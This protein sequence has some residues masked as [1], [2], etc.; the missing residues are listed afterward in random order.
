MTDEEIVVKLTEYHKEIDSL[1][2]RTGELEE[3]N[4]MIQ[5]LVLSVKELALN[6]RNMME[7]QKRQGDRLALLEKEPADR[8]RQIRTAVITA[9]ASGIIG[10]VIGAVVK[11]L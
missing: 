10:I 4:K 8:L 6:M 1:N 11:I 2:H 5:D 7:E 9:L 3:Q